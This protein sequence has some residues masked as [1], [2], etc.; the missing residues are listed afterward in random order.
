MCSFEKLDIK[1]GDIR[2]QEFKFIMTLA[3][4]ILV[5]FNCTNKKTS[6]RVI[7]QNITLKTRPPFIINIH[8]IALLQTTYCLLFILTGIINTLQALGDHTFFVS[9]KMKNANIRYFAL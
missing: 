6:T 7:Y 2:G 8:L 1:I 9:K 3:N 5:Q 4:T